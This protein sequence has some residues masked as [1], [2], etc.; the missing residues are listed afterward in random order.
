MRSFKKI[1]EGL[2]KPDTIQTLPMNTNQYGYTEQCST[3]DCITDVQI[4]IDNLKFQKVFE[5]YTLSKADI[6]GAFDGT[7][8]Q[9]LLEFLNMYMLCPVMLYMFKCIL[10]YQH[11]RIKLGK[12]H[13]N[14]KLCQKGIIQ[15]SKISPTLFIALLNWAYE[16][17]DETLRA[18]KFLFC[19]DMF[20]IAKT[21][22]TEHNTRVTKVKLN[23]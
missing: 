8:H 11:V 13:S 9:A 4:V 3:M 10:L 7:S 22:D 15:G 20:Y 17:G 5:E 23:K 14:Y 18:F 1:L 16:Q 6:S 19:D 12:Y 21:K 2:V